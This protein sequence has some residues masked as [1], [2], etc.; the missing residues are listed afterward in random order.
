MK[1]AGMPKRRNSVTS[2][3]T[4]TEMMRMIRLAM[5]GHPT[6]LL[7]LKLMS[8]LALVPMQVMHTIRRT[9]SLLYIRLWNIFMAA[10]AVTILLSTSI[11]CTNRKGTNTRNSSPSST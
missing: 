7:G 10:S 8:F 4:Q 3:Y 1:L 2:G 11:S 5:S 6:C 9:P